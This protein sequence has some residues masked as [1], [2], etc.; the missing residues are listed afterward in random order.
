LSISFCRDTE[1]LNRRWYEANTGQVLTD[2]QQEVRH[3]TLRW[4]AATP[5]GRVAP[6]ASVARS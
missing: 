5:D 6:A 1:E 4:M 2:V 3:P